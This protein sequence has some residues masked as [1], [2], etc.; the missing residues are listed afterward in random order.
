M[1]ADVSGIRF[2]P[3]NDFAGVELKHG[4]L[5]LDGDVNELDAVIGRR[6]RAAASDI[7]GR[8]TVS[9]N[10]PDAFKITPLAAGAFSIGKG[11]LYVDGLL[12][13]NHGRA[14]TEP[15]KKLFDPLMAEVSFAD[16]IA[17]DAQPYLPSP[18]ALPRDG[19]YLVYLDVWEREVTHLQ[20]PDLV[21][22]AVGV[23]TSSRVQTVWQV[24]VLD[25]RGATCGS[26]DK[27]VPG[28]PELIAPST[29]RLTTGTFD[30]P[31]EK[32]PCELPPT[33]GYRGLE[34]QTYRVEIHD[35]GQPGGTATFK[36][37]RDNAS[38]AVSVVSMVSA[39]ELE[40]QTLGRD[41]VLRF[42]AG[43]W[44]EIT[45]DVRE[46]S[47]RCGEMRRITA[48]NEAARRITFTPALPAEMVPAA[49]PSSDFPRERNS[50]V[51][52]WDQAHDV[53]RTGPGGTTLPFQDL[54][55]VGSTGVVKV[56]VA[57]TTLLLENG[58]T[59][60]FASTATGSGDNGFRA[61][62]FWVFAA[63]TADASVELLA[64]EPPR[65]IHHHYER[66]GLWDVA[67]GTVTDCRHPWPPA[68]PAGGD[69]CACT[70]CVTP[71][72]HASGQMTIQ[73]AID[74]VIAA[75][76]GTV[77]L[78]V[79]NYALRAPVKIEGTSSVKL[80]GKGIASQLLAIDAA[81]AVLVNK[82]HDVVLDSFSVLCRGSINAP[83]E[84][85]GVVSSYSIRVEHLAIHVAS[86]NPQWAAIGLAGVLIDL[87]LRENALVAPTGIRSGSTP[88]GGGEA[89]LADMRIED[90]D[91]DCAVT[92][93]AFAPVTVHQLVNR[94]CGNRVNGC[95]EAGLL[96]TGMTAPGFGLEVQ[97]NVF[98]VLGHGIVTSLNGLR[99]LDNDILQA[100]GADP[101]Q[102][103]GIFLV[104]GPTASN[105]ITDCQVLGN[106]IQGF[107][108]AGIF[109]VAPLRTAMIK[110][111]QIAQVKDG[112]V[113][114]LESGGVLDQLSIE[115]N[116][117]K[118]ITGSAILA[119]GEDAS[120]VATGNQIHTRSQ[121]TAVQLEFKGGE[122]VFSH[123]ECYRD[124]G[125]DAPD[126][127]LQS[128][129]LIV[130]NNRVVGGG[131][132]LHIGAAR[133]HY[134]VLGNIC[135]GKIKVEP[136]ADLPTPWLA[137]NLESV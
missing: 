52:R 25:A 125:G 71:K 54:D 65:G 108:H 94:I 1:G 111:N 36:W 8:S 88:S 121:E 27:E 30:V 100:K 67:A 103:R 68:I 6:L 85:V 18:P 5:V 16:P 105:P 116:Q 89:G 83:Q 12:A 131:F 26:P 58:V 35:P 48:V 24:R 84:A 73:M 29:G 43:D 106:R 51:I 110:Q 63:R 57:G 122:G 47:Q 129:T 130:G 99:V 97:A 80:V 123:N 22:V 120:Y 134:T 45:D 96:L 92:A 127:R 55:A 117:F 34:N 4:G 17:Y 115:N 42:N 132:S 13:E 40:L 37:S 10:T 113:L 87:S 33:G 81:G 41:D 20:R 136:N 118:D 7:L 133:Q 3:L 91:F 76:G 50:R 72:D 23:E 114:A 90:N 82:S 86:E 93:I 119:K 14:S 78:E 104:T 137:L 60:S 11:R 109:V 49:F 79:G 59:V 53:R 28:W 95:K 128:N 70:V 39:G 75:G 126:V 66:L 107:D 135:H 64:N 56:P 101:K 74:Q 98:S 62:D 31:P 61:G 69:S 102:Q 77:C 124:G 38:V 21:E 19:R 112:L 15:E 44:V 46:L 9:S 32:D 2:N